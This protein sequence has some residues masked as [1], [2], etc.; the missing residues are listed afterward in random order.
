MKKIVPTAEVSPGARFDFRN[1][2]QARYQ[3]RQEHDQDEHV[4]PK[5][6]HPGVKQRVE[7][8]AP[9]A[10]SA[11]QCGP[12]TNKPG[13]VRRAGDLAVPHQIFV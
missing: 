2:T 5:D 3:K 7:R 8:D 1:L 12:K 4:L 11:P 6:D 10:L 13:T 9:R